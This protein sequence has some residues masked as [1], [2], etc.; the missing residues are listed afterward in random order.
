M[1]KNRTAETHSESERK[2]TRRV[3]VTNIVKAERNNFLENR[4]EKS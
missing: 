3:E 4:R 1:N 2:Q